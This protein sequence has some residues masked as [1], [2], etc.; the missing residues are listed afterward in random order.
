MVFS[1]TTNALLRSILDT[2]QQR[3]LKGFLYRK[4]LSRLASIF[5][6]DK[7][8]SH[9]YTRHYQHHFRTLRREK[10]NILEI[11]IGG[12]ENPK[13]GGGS[14]RMWKQYFPK[15]HIFG[16]DIYD[17]TYHDETRI[18]TFRGSQTDE[19]FLRKVVETIG[20]VDIII[21][22]GSHHN[23]HVI[24]TFKILFPLLS[25]NGIYVVEDVQTSYWA[26]FDGE[27]WGGSSDLTAPYTSMNF[28][29]SLIDGLNHQEF[30]VEYTP[31]YFDEHIVA[32]HFYH[33]LIF[34]YK[35]VN[36]EGSNAETAL[37]R[38]R[39]KLRQMSHRG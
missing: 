15:S 24:T 16:I 20:T 6:T 35:G 19:C 37:M 14:L 8:G 36:N 34:I 21:D 7:H 1:K 5:R 26:E 29:K 33:N 17:K 9:Y 30:T 4:D 31:T 18:R 38:H 3:S 23:D 27:N 12:F 32:M 25:Q 2:R 22:D 39:Q 13:G 11:G 10:L 28:F